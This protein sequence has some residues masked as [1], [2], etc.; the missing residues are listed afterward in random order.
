LLFTSTLK[1]KPSINKSAVAKIDE[2][3]EEEKKDGQQELGV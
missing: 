3:K 1:G 2:E